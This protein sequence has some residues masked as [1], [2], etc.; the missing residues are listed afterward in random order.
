MITKTLDTSGY[1]PL[2]IT[3]LTA[4]KSLTVQNFSPNPLYLAV[5]GVT[6]TGVTSITGARPGLML[7]QYE[8]FSNEQ[9]FPND[10]LQSGPVYG[11]WEGTG[12]CAV[13]E[14]AS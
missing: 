13:Q 10:W 1:R 6:T 8:I 5:D 14:R 11:I 3:S 4:R 7:R 2:P 9:S 12:L